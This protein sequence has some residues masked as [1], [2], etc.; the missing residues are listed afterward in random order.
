MN[1]ILLIF[2]ILFIWFFPLIGLIMLI[3]GSYMMND[4][5]KRVDK[6]V[7][8]REETNKPRIFIENAINEEFIGQ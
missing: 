3:G 5:F 6:H 4:L 7:K 1:V 8:K 2:G